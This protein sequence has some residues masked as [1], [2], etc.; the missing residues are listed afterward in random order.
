[1]HWGRLVLDRLLLGALVLAVRA[2]NVQSTSDHSAFLPHFIFTGDQNWI[3]VQGTWRL[4]DGDDA[5]PSQTT[6]I[7]CSRPTVRCIEASAAI[8]RSDL[9]LPVSIKQLRVL[10]WDKDVVITEGAGGRCVDAVYEF[11]LTT[12]AVTGLQTRKNDE[13]CQTS[14]AAAVAK[15]ESKM[16]MVDGYEDSWARRRR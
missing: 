1:M 6:P 13:W 5:Y 10:R 16:H 7:E 12:K 11:H 2:L 8:T 14:P 4:D 15:Q 3:S 9:V